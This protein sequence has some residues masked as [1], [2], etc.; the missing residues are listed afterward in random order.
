MG[1]KVYI[2][3]MGRPAT[4]EQLREDFKAGKRASKR[5]NNRAA[6]KTARFTFLSTTPSQSRSARP[7]AGCP[8]RCPIDSASQSSRRWL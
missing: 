1:M 2:E 4:R 5:Q 7:F 8:C 3:H 6:T